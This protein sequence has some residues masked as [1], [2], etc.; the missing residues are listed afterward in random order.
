MAKINLSD[1][2]RNYQK[3]IKKWMGPYKKLMKSPTQPKNVLE[4][5]LKP[6][7]L[8]LPKLPTLNG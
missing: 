7:G 6:H 8:K 5:Q 3:G 2:T 4:G 1:L